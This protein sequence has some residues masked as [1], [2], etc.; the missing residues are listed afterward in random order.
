MVR[1]AAGHPN[2][3]RIFLTAFHKKEGL[4]VKIRAHAASLRP[5]SMLSVVL[6]VWTSTPKTRVHI[7]LSLEQHEEIRLFKTCLEVL[8]P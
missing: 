3:S 6:M 4:K 5:L 7:S 8:G 1:D 2:A